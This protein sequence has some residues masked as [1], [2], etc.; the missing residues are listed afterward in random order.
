MITEL[1]IPR[2][3]LKSKAYIDT[4]LFSHLQN[5]NEDWIKNIF[6]AIKAWFSEDNFITAKT[7][8]TTGKAKHIKLLKKDIE[9]SALSTLKALSI[10]GGQTAFVSLPMDYIAGKMMVFRSL[11]GGL[12]IIAVKPSQSPLEALEKIIHLAAMTPHQA[13]HSSLG[14]LN[15]VQKLLIGGS[16]V[17]NELIDKLAQTQT[18]AYESYGM[19]ETISHIA[20]RKITPHTS[21]RFQTLAGVS[22][23]TDHKSRLRILDGRFSPKKQMMTQDIVKINSPTSF[24][25][26]GRY[27]NLI[28]S[29]GI[30]IIPE[31]VEKK[32]AKQITQPFF[33]HKESDI[34]L[35]E[36]VV[37]VIEDPLKK[38][39]DN[40]TFDKIKPHEKPKKIYF[41]DKFQRTKSGKIRRK[42]TFQHLLKE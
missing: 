38:M 17:Q 5:D 24:Q 10:H 34:A 6:L 22:V 13:H 36:K 30:K 32:I 16:K 29:G 7:S 19:T 15:K 2:L 4:Y 37:L 8:G 12:D 31:E 9:I 1:F 39:P 42:L 3:D 28:N 27:D 11:I 41:S 35:G 33:L 20:L 40:T 18:V 25:W 23:D 14:S 26:L 21:L